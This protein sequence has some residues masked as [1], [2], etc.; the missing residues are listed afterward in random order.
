MVVRVV[1]GWMLA[2]LATGT[3][4]QA[5]VPTVSGGLM[6]KVGDVAVLVVE[7]RTDHKTVEE[8]VTVTA[9]DGGLIRSRHVRADR[10]PT[11]YEG[12]ITGDFALVVSGTSGARYDP[13]I[14]MIKLPAVVGSA[15]NS[16][17]E[18]QAMNQS[19]SRSDFDFK[20]VGAE[21]LTTPAGEFDT[22]K[23]EQTGWINGVSWTGSMR[24]ANTMWY[25]PAI[26]RLV[27]TEFRSYRNAQLW[28]HT[29]TQLKS[30]TPGP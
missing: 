19:R 5:L 15:W 9:L 30:F 18:V 12:V 25:A 8:T 2:C 28:E 17:S 26:G 21:K 11:E 22:F 23:V 29:V 7:Q 24:V 16:R 3:W 14:P 27:R 20:I 10:S 1:F 4:A 6:Y 13:P